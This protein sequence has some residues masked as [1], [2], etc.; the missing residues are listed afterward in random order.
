MFVFAGEIFIVMY[1]QRLIEEE[2]AL[3]LKSS[4]AVVVAG[5]KLAKPPHACYTRKVS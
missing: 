4:G 2:I 1:Y 3:K 5:P